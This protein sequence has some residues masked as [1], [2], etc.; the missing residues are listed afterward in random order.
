MPGGKSSKKKLFKFGGGASK[1]SRKPE[2]IVTSR[3]APLPQR[4][5]ANVA[6]GLPPLNLHQQLNLRQQN[7]S[8]PP[9]N[10]R[11]PS[12]DYSMAKPP[13]DQS[14][15]RPPV[16]QKQVANGD[17][18]SIKQQLMNHDANQRPFAVVTQCFGSRTL[19]FD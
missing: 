11:R 17:F 5:Q 4:Q 2:S 15:T 10:G 14:S 6:G 18:A 1:K 7:F 8:S 12:V 9:L 19:H 3:T 13:P 16:Q